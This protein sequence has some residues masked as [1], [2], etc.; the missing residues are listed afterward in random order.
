M[1]YEDLGKRVRRQRQALQWTQEELAERAGVSTSFVG[2]VERGS[3]KTSIETLVALANALDVTTDYLLAG[4]LTGWGFGH[5]PQDL[6]RHQ[7]T[8]MQEIFTA[9][10]TQLQAWDNPEETHP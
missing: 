8:V 6:N 2:H 1:D 7:R 4:S 3:R 9:M 5:K 10:Q